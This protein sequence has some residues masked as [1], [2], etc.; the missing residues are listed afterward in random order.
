LKVVPPIP[1]PTELSLLEQPHLEEEER[2][3]EY[4]RGAYFLTLMPI[5][6]RH[7]HRHGR[8]IDDEYLA[9]LKGTRPRQTF[10]LDVGRQRISELDEELRALWTTMRDIAPAYAE[11]RL[12]PAADREV[13]V[14]AICSHA[15]S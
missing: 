8:I 9:E 3:L 12:H 1:T 6:P 15:T 4:L 7:Y 14:R 5:L 2:L 10:D 13:L 11:R